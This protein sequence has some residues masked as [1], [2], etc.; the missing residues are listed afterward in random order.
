MTKNITLAIDETLLAEVQALVERRNTSLNA[1]I[2]D[3]L[4]QVVEQEVRIDRAKAG[5]KQLIDNAAQM[6]Q[7]GEPY[8]WNREEIYAERLDRLLSRHPDP[9]LRGL[10]DKSRS[11]Q[12]SARG[13]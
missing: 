4:S 11:P 8:V 6:D 5:M 1:L 12:G 7:A 13:G 10:E 3:L 2:L 9:D